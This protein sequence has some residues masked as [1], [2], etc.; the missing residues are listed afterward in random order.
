MAC[1]EPIRG[2]FWNCHFEPWSDDECD[3]RVNAPSSSLHSTPAEG[4]F[5]L[6]KFKHQACIFYGSSVESGLDPPATK[7]RL[8][9]EVVLKKTVTSTG[10]G[11][12]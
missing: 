10:E 9:H 5:I 7:P 2:L 12:L 1:I 3:T 11:N 4:Y 6:Y 8:C